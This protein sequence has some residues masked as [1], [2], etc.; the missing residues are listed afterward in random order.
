VNKMDDASI[1]WSE[2]RYEEIKSNL[3]SFI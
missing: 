2:D 1:K 3:S